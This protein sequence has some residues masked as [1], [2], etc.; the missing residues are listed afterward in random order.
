MTT[1]IM[2]KDQIK[3]GVEYILGNKQH[4]MKS[5]VKKLISFIYELQN[6]RE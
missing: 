6:Q 1:P 5:R 4:P 2:T 3:D